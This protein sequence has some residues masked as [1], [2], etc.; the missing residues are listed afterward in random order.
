MDSFGTMK[1]LNQ[2][3][4]GSENKNKQYSSTDFQ[5][6]ERWKINQTSNELWKVST[7]III[8]TDI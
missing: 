5:T 4:G 7:K 1:L 8:D 2:N 3:Y 6:L